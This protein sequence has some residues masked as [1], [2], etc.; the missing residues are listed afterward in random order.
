M[1]IADD[2]AAQQPFDR[3]KLVEDNC[4]VKK[5]EA[6]IL[7]RSISPSPDEGAIYPLALQHLHHFRQLIRR[8]QALRADADLIVSGLLV[9]RGLNEN[10]APGRSCECDLQAV[11]RDTCAHFNDGD[12]DGVRRRRFQCMS[13]AAA[14]FCA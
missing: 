3:D 12:A 14:T 6:K 4:P 7:Q 2:R 1:G 11:E 8:R 13:D 5:F 9:S 10:S